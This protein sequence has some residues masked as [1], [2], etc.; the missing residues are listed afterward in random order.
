MSNVRR[1]EPRGD[2]DGGTVV[3]LPGET[4]SGIARQHDVSVTALIKSNHLKD[5][6]RLRVGQMLVIP[7]KP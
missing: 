1:M 4:L 6:N 5:G 2:V 3:V 7:R